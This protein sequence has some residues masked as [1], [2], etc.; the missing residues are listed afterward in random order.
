MS[1]TPTN[2]QTGDIITAEKLNNMENGIE[3][4]V[5]IVHE[6]YDESTDT[7]TLDKTW[8]EIVDANFA[9]IN[10]REYS[11]D[12]TPAIDNLWIAQAAHGYVN[13]NISYYVDI[14]SMTGN[15]DSTVNLASTVFTTDSPDGYPSVTG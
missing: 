13:D 14:I 9:V 6:N 15:A 4:S 2:W 8:Q 11:G 5:L 7:T 10:I 3:N 1:Y 12:Q